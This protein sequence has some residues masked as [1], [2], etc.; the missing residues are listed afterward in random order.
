MTLTELARQLRPLMEKAAASLDD[1]DAL[2]GVQLFPHWRAGIAVAAGQRYQYSGALYK[3]Q[4]AHTTQEGWEPPATPALWVAV[5]ADPQ[6]GTVDNPIPA[7]RGMEYTYGLYYSD[8]GKV[9]LCKRTGEEDGGTVILQYLPHEL[10]GQYFE[11]V[12]ENE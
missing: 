11:E 9:Y 7:V 12:T 1:A 6:Q 10:V 8:G 3:V 5:A 4:Q 2:Q